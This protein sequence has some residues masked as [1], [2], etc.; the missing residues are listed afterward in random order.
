MRALYE[1]NLSEC[2]SVDEFK[3][4]VSIINRTSRKDVKEENVIIK[5][6]ASGMQKVLQQRRVYILWNA[7][8]LREFENVLKSFNCFGFGHMSRERKY[9][10]TVCRKC[11]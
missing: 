10:E 8:K 9:K 7:F 2:I 5:I 6:N 1:T 3:E 11:F 4:C